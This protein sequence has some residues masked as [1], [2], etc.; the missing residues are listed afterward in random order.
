MKQDTCCLYT[1]Q[2]LH[3]S[4]AGWAGLVSGWG[5]SRTWAPC[6]KGNSTGYRPWSEHPPPPPPR[7]LL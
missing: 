6:F 5:R 1:D 7:E 3:A 4:S 2:G